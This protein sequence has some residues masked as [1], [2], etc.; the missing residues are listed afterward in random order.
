MTVKFFV[1][2]KDKQK[3]AIRA[4][5]SFFGKQYYYAIGVTVNPAFWNA[6]K[7]RCRN[8]RDYDDATFVNQ[9]LDLWEVILKNAARDFEMKFVSPTQNEF[10]KA[11]ERALRVHN[12]ENAND[13]KTPYIVEFAEHFKNN[14][15]NSAGCKKSYEDTIRHLAGYEKKYKTKL[16]FSDITM[17]FYHSFK[18]FLTEKTYIKNEVVRQYTKNTIANKIKNIKFFFNEGRRQKYHDLYIEGFA[19]EREE[20]DSI[21]LT[22]E[23]LVR[24][25][26]LE[27]TEDLMLD[28]LGNIFVGK[29]E[30]NQKIAELNDNKDRFLIGAFTAMRYGDYSGIENLK[31]TDKF[32]SKR[33]QKTGIKVIIPMH[34]II[35]E[36]LEHRNNVLPEFVSNRDL[37]KDLKLLGK[38]ADI[39]DDVTTT[40]TRGGKKITE[41]HKKYELIQTHTARRSGCTNMYLAG[42]DIYTI[43]GFSGHTTE[44]SFRKYIKIK[45][46]ENAQRFVNH[47]F[48]KK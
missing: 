43:M 41:A 8:D 27:I 44:S 47:P 2:S 18:N 33:T 3:S 25:H 31:S 24:L 32:I 46:E 48:F 15:S 20:S 37:N 11:V 42:I 45:Q 9:K 30:I 35:R 23:E 21:Y 34:W 6:K 1:R 7:N 4:I 22:T 13:E 36:I 16:K 29:D 5:V 38:L 28:K 17:D 26:R 39:N 14:N 12:G 19:V 10:S 40:I